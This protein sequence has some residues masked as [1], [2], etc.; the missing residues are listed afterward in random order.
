[1]LLETGAYI[2]AKARLGSTKGMKN[3]KLLY[4]LVP[5]VLLIWGGLFFRI[6]NRMNATAPA[7]E[8]FRN[9]GDSMSYQGMND[10]FSIAP[11]Y[12]DPFLH[13][14]AS[15]RESDAK[16]VLKQKPKPAPEQ[17]VKWPIVLYY[18]MIKNQES[19]KQLVLVQVD[20]VS[21]RLKP[22]DRIGGLEL[23]KVYRDSLALSFGKEIKMIR[24]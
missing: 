7:V 17:N 1:M 19:N 23:K 12:R 4:L 6:Y 21:H 9:Q 15:F 2:A 18:G 3:K 11:N 24:K 16:H 20:G 10:T 14:N 8:A 22:G 5:A 13:K